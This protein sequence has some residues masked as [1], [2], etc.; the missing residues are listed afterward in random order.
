LGTDITLDLVS[1]DGKRASGSAL[2]GSSLVTSKT[3]FMQVLMRLNKNSHLIE[4][5]NPPH[6]KTFNHPLKKTFRIWHKFPQL[7]LISKCR[8]KVAAALN[9]E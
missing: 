4:R 2:P 3:R 7:I 6:G 1:E 5:P 8:N 9:Y